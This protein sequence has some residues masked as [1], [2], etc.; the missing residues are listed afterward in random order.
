MIDEKTLIKTMSLVTRIACS[1]N[2][3][4]PE[5]SIDDLKGIGSLAMMNAADR[6]DTS[7]G[8][9]LNFASAMIKGRMQDEFRKTSRYNRTTGKKYDP[10]PNTF[11]EV[12]SETRPD[13][14]AI[15]T[16]DTE[17][18]M[19]A[20]STLSPRRRD[21]LE[22]RYFDGESNAS[23]AKRIGKCD[24]TVSGIQRVARHKLRKILGSRDK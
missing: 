3:L 18:L 1:Q 17:R 20:L 7:K 14:S 5:Y 9:W 23:I 2:K 15:K 21:I 22:S 16:D 11:I 10:L 24:M 19:A 13:E 4:W 12:C 6:Y 8:S